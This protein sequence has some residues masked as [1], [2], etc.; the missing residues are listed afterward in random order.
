M[1]NTVLQNIGSLLEQNVLRSM[2][3][4]GFNTVRFLNLK[5]GEDRLQPNAINI[6]LFGTTAARDIMGSP[7]FSTPTSNNMGIEQKPPLKLSVDILFIFN[8]S[9]YEIALAIYG[10]VLGYFYNNDLL[11]VPFDG[12]PNDVQILLSSFNDRDEIELWNSFGISGTPILR[13][14]LKYVM[15]SGKT[16]ELPIVRS[17]SV[18]GGVMN[19]EEAGISSLVLNM[20]YYPIDVILKGITE[21]TNAFCSIQLTGDEVKDNAEI[22][23][24]FDELTQSYLTADAKIKVLKAELSLMMSEERDPAYPKLYAQFNPFFPSIDGLQRILIEDRTE[25]EKQGSD[26]TTQNYEALCTLAQSFT[27]GSGSLT[28]TFLQQLSTTSAYLVITT[29]IDDQIVRFNV[30]GES[31]YGKLDTTVLSNSSDQLSLVQLRVKWWELEDA[32]KTLSRIYKEEEGNA[33]LQ[34]NET[35]YTNFRNLLLE[36]QTQLNQPIEDFSTLNNTYN[37]GSGDGIN[38][39]VRMAYFDAYKNAFRSVNFLLKEAIPIRL[40]ESLQRIFE[41]QNNKQNN[42]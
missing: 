40:A 20:I 33:L 13:Y 36:C 37:H 24:R 39:V 21:K 1:F 8:F 11:N 42:N 16:R 28:Q 34:I 2:E 9:N 31:T 6:I 12:Y 23:H 7:T 19:P 17:V 22:S 14:D 5:S 25:L 41:T 29:T 10:Q 32:L 38:P 3:G 26:P 35:A 27:Q 15:L 30:I 4:T 18:N